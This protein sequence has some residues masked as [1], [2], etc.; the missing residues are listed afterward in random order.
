MLG[1]FEVTMIG[2][3]LNLVGWN[4]VTCQIGYAI[5]TA[6]VECEWQSCINQCPQHYHTVPYLFVGE[7]WKKQNRVGILVLF[8]YLQS[9]AISQNAD[10]TTGEF[11]GLMFDKPYYGFSVLYGD[12]FVF[13]SAQVAISQSYVAI[14]YKHISYLV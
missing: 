12:V 13:Q 2:E 1:G 11:I 10:V 5:M 3:T 9:L 8:Q 14:E 4:S 7:F 6:T